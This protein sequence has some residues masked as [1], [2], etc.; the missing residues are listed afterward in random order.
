MR[1]FREQLE[2]LTVEELDKL[3]ASLANEIQRRRGPL[4][5]VRRK[6]RKDKDRRPRRT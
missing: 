3:E 5:S 6:V 1:S 2:A 4:G